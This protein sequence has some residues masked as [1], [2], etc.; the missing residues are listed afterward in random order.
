MWIVL[1]AVLLIAVL[2]NF[3]RRDVGYALVILWAVAGIAL[4]HAATAGVATPA[5]ITFAL[6]AVTLIG[7]FF[8]KKPVLKGAW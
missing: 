1:A 8:V 5:W 7:A 4:K 2:V 3:T 6:V